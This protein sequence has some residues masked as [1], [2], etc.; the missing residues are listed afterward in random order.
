MHQVQR[1]ISLEGQEQTTR[2]ANQAEVQI[3]LQAPK[4]AQKENNRDR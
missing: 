4:V 1:E 2:Q 3:N